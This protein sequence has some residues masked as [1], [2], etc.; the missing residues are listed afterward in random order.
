[1]ELNKNTEKSPVYKRFL[2]I[3]E[4]FTIC[5]N[6]GDAEYVLAE[7]PSER[8]TL[9]IYPIK[10]KAKLGHI[11]QSDYVT[12]DS[13]ENKLLN[14]K[15]YLNEV[16][17]FQTE[18]DF[19]FIG[20]NTL[21]KNIDWDGRL[22]TNEESLLVIDKPNSYFVCLNGKVTIND[23]QFKRFDYASVDVGKEYSIQINENS[24]LGLFSKLG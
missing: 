6:I 22:I 24:A 1:M 8:H 23:K 14:I 3:Y 17:V 12:I 4:D 20:F 15:E 13:N 19:Y 18:T 2:K 5:V 7:H 9:Y 21:N 11:F 16:V 10:G